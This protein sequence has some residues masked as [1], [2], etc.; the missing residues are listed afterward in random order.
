[1]YR[2]TLACSGVPGSEGAEAA[3]DITAEFADHRPHYANVVCS[4]DAG[5]LMLVAESDFDADG[6]N[7]MDEFSDCIAAYLT[8]F[9]GDIWLVASVAI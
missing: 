9:D 5:R 4:F 2:V 1:M 6:L 8:A 7:L 3:A